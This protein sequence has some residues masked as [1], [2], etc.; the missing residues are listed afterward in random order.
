MPITSWSYEFEKLQEG[1]YAG[2]YSNTSERKGEVRDVVSRYQAHERTGAGLNDDRSS[3]MG[4]HEAGHLAFNQ[5]SIRSLTV[6]T[7][8]LILSSKAG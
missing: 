2:S 3:Q 6:S 7:V 4:A 5:V 1:N 8:A